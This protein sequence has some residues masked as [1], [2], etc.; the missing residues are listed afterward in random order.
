MVFQVEEEF[1]V[2][3]NKLY[4]NVIGY[5]IKEYFGVCYSIGF[6][7]QVLQKL[8]FTV[9]KATIRV[10]FRHIQDIMIIALG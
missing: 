8:F 7:P 2:L 4:L 10:A 1:C 3:F 6:L 9:L 5:V